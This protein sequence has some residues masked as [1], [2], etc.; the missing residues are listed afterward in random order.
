MESMADVSEI[1]IKRQFQQILYSTLAALVLA[2]DAGFLF[3]EQ[4]GCSKGHLDESIGS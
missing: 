2:G 3:A 1:L 4:L